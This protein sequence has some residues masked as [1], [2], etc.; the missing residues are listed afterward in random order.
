MAAADSRLDPKLARFRTRGRSL[1]LKMASTKSMTTGKSIC[2]VTKSGIPGRRRRRHI[3]LKIRGTGTL[4]LISVRTTIR[5]L[6][7]PEPMSL[8]RPNN[9]H[10]GRGVHPT[11]PS[12]SPSNRHP[13]RARP[14]QNRHHRQPTMMH[15]TLG[16][17]QDIH[18]STGILEKSQSYCWAVYLTPT[19]SANGS[20]TGLLPGMDRRHQCQRSQVTCG[21]YSSN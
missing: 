11:P 13:R 14:Q 9:D 16:S 7:T 10:P 8:L 21:C 17:R 19:H 6:S 1:S 5:F 15:G 20:M 18:S 2:L 3:L 4:R 12:P